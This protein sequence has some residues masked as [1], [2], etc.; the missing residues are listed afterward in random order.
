MPARAAWKAVSALRG[1]P[2][3]FIGRAQG[4]LDRRVLRV[5][6][7][8]GVVLLGGVGV[9]LVG[10]QSVGEQQTGLGVGR[11]ELHGGPPLGDGLGSVALLGIEVAQRG[12]RRGG[13]RVGLRGR[14]QQGHRLVGLAVVGE[15][16][17]EV[18]LGAEQSLRVGRA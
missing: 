7:G 11:V 3:L 17:A 4:V 9:F 8:D 6:L 2:Q 13:L 15:Q 18:G 1:L 16:Q 14:R 5:A 12:V 10:Q